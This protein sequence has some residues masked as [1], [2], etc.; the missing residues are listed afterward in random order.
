VVL[1]SEGG[2]GKTHEQFFYPF[3]KATTTGLTRVAH[4]VPTV[5]SYGLFK[6]GSV[7]VHS[8]TFINSNY[9]CLFNQIVSLRMTSIAKTHFIT[10]FLLTQ[11]IF[12]LTGSFR[13]SQTFK[14]KS[15]LID[16]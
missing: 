1:V 3:N 15:D 2:Y 12:L 10:L 9:H 5:P 13:S 14:I 7:W 11:I 6:L 8:S 4:F 16:V